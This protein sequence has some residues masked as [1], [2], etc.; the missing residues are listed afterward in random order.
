M[1]RYLVRLALM[2]FGLGLLV[3]LA[4]LMLERLL[5]LIDMMAGQGASFGR[6][7]ELL[8]FLM[9][10]YLGL[11][12][13]AALFLASMIAFRRLVDSS[14]YTVLVAAGITPR[15]LLV[16]TLL[17]S[18]L[19][20]GVMLVVSGWIDPL[21]RYAYRRTAYE[22]SA[23]GQMLD[24]YP[25]TFVRL[26]DTITLRAETIAPDGSLRNVFLVARDPAANQTTYVSARAATI[27]R[28]RET[29]AVTLVLADG[30][31]IIDGGG[32]LGRLSFLTYPWTL[33]APAADS[34]GPRGRDERELTL[35]ELP[36]H[37]DAA[38]TAADSRSFRTELQSRLVQAASLPFLLLLSLPL[39][40]LGTG[41]RGRAYGLVLGIM[42]MIFYDKLLGF[43]EAAAAKGRVPLLLGLW[44]PLTL[45]AVCSLIALLIKTP[46]G[47]RALKRKNAENRMLT[48]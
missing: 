41:R 45:L 40:L 27:D 6:I 39:A 11:A 32:K 29:D 14:E 9:P 18:I 26:T 17:I 30:D 19:L 22:L 46:T 1:D 15:R 20:V 37:A 21:A 24:F 47:A 38:P 8:G 13:P 2:P 12:V 44:G 16:P 7:L 35:S 48:A 33:P 36:R 34:Y 23:S 31:S 4:G 43:G 3:L 5:R 28:D 25:Q 10:H 42:L